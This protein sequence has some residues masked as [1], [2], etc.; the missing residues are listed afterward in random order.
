[1]MKH[2]EAHAEWCNQQTP[3]P[4][5]S[6]GTLK[7]KLATIAS[8]TEQRLAKQ[9][10]MHSSYLFSSCPFANGHL[11]TGGYDACECTSCLETHKSHTLRV[12]ALQSSAHSLL[13]VVTC[14]DNKY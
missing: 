4:S 14:T 8:Q 3:V 11:E 2:D 9:G 13:K 12:A 6:H 5:N 1:M 10:Q 7:A